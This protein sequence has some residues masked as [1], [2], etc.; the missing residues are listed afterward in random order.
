MRV[1]DLF[2]RVAVATGFLTASTTAAN[3]CP[4][5]VALAG[6]WRLYRD[7]DRV[8]I[9]LTPAVPET[10][11]TTFLDVGALG[12]STSDYYAVKGLSLCSLTP[13]P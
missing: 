7:G 6:Q 9:G 5:V 3:P 13:G 8:S 4:D 12:R 10:G 2:G 1:V 11:A